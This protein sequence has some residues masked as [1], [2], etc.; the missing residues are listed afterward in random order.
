MTVAAG[1]YL[2]EKFTD[3]RRESET[4]HSASRLLRLTDGEMPQLF[5]EMRAD[6]VEPEFAGIR[7]FFVLPNRNVTMSAG[8][9]ILT[10]F[11]DEHQNL[12][13][14]LATLEERGYIRDITPGNAPKYRMSHDL[15]TYLRGR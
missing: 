7:D 4:A 8:G 10:Y 5:A 14:K 15:I 3:R 1:T 12:S 11:E 2:A 6:L 9:N 13:G